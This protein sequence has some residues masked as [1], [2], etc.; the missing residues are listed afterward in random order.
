MMQPLSPLPLAQEDGMI[1]LQS[2]LSAMAVLALAL[3]AVG[4]AAAEPYPQRP[5]KIIAAVVAGST[6]DFV[7]RAVA[8][9]LSAGMTQ[10]FVVENRP[11][12]GGNIGAEFVAKSAADGHTLLV[13]IGTTLTVNPTVYKTMSFDPDADLRPISIL[14]TSS[15]ALTV[16]PSVPVNSV[17]EF[18][19]FAKNEALIYAVGGIGTPGHLAMEYFG[20][21]A[22]FRATPVPY[23]GNAPLVTDLVAGQVKVAFPAIGS[24]VAHVRDGRVRALAVSG[25][26]RSPLAPQV[27]RIAE[28]GYPDFKVDTQ[29]VL[30][31]PAAIPDAV[32]A[33]LERKTR[34]ALSAP[35]LAEKLRDHGYD[36]AATTG[37]EAKARLQAERRLW[38]DVIR[39]AGIHVH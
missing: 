37:A 38:A 29:M 5:V 39:A 1:A 35:G 19:A 21:Q 30:L 20:R 2:R 7:A 10:T 18:V 27:P 17:S 4:G 14:T 26:A 25:G 6:G 11:G 36:I 32:A 15:L 34:E 12:A 22:G 3:S 31:A 28:L 24:V 9:R 13:A 23:R 8:E 16:H 33:L